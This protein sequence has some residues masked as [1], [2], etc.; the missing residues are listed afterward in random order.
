MPKIVLRGH[1]VLPDRVLSPGFVSIEGEKI[2]G[3]F[4]RQEKMASGDHK[5]IDYGD[6]YIA[7]GFVDLHLHGALGK[8]VMDCQEESL[9]LIAIHQSRS[10]VTG[11]L[12][13][14]MSASLDLVI[15]AVRTIK[16]AIEHRFPSGIL[17]A[18]VEGPFLNIE[19]KGAHDLGYIKGLTEDDLRRLIE[20]AQGIKVVISLAPE[21]GNNMDYISLLKKNGFVV[22][23]GHSDATYEEALESFKKG[24]SHTTHLFNAMR[25]FDHREPGVAGAVLD[26]DEVSAELI[27]DGIHLHPASLR[28]AVASKGPE[29]ICLVTDSLKATGEG[30]GVYYWGDREIE[31]KGRRATLKGTDVLAGSVLTMNRAVK[32]MI[33][34]TGISV[35]QAVNM[36]SLNPARVLGLEDEIGSIGASKYAN[37]AILDRNFNVLETM[38]RGE[39]VF[40]KSR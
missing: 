31:V 20:A 10:G 1:V 33:D 8:D 25:G 11:F 16:K 29:K 18:H 12:G 32:N 15:E 7:P 28:L 22:A 27:A 24:I 13:S 6:A 37:L 26:S 38:Y 17:G 3:V 5:S 9:R 21:V 34:W 30:D 23:I 35:N 40:E 36:A 19:K 2:A 14:T 39:F 4:D